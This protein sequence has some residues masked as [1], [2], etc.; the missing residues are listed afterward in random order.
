VL[1]WTL[2]AAAEDAPDEL[3]TVVAGDPLTGDGAVDRTLLT[4]T[5]LVGTADTAPAVPTGTIPDAAFALPA[6]ATM[7]AHQFSGRLDLLDENTVG[8]YTKILDTHAILGIGAVV[9]HIPEVSLELTQTGSHL[10][11][12]VQGIQITGHRFWNLIVGPG[13]AWSEQGDEGW[14]RAALPFTL[15]QRNAN[16]AHVG[17][18]MFLYDDTRVSQVRYQITQETCPYFKYD[19]WGQA[20]ASYTPYEV[21]DADAVR[22]AH[23][24]EVADR[25][26]TRPISQLAADHPEADLDLTAFGSGIT[27]EHLSTYGLLYQGVNYVSDCA[28]RQGTY[29]FCEAM[30]MS[31]FSVAKSAF[32]ATA[33][34]LLAQDRG[35][36]VVDEPIGAWV[37]E[38]ADPAAGW[39]DVTIGNVLDMAS[40]HYESADY[41]VDE[42]G[43]TANSF[44]L[45]ETYADRIA[46][47]LGFPRQA[48]PGTRWVY[49]TADTFVATTA[50]QNILGSDLFDHV[51]DRVYVPAK[52]SRGALTTSRTDNSP[53]GVPLG[54]YGLFLTRDDIAKLAMLFNNDGG[55]IAG[56]QVLDPN[57]LAAAMQRDPEDPGLPTTESA[58]SWY[59]NG[60]WAAPITP[61]QHPRYTCSF[62]VP[63]MSGYG[64][65]GV[66]MMPNGATYYYV[67]DNEE[68]AWVPAL[69]EADKLSPHCPVK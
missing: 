19:M 1:P 27:P 39:S 63:F 18:F 46:V 16:C 45:A 25:L 20:E 56:E 42:N 53:T 67:S 17:T 51:R 23:A 21:P 4:V 43:W 54:G 22:A 57:L 44:V 37:P 48:D 13:R 38:A 26:P 28:T 35:P 32:A 24:A 55:R 2:A 64:G 7:P 50:M 61:E 58:G 8:G 59:N 69:D 10:I 29:P 65:I 36:G 3:D 40:G 33:L 52:L 12:T 60:F 34:M 66:M 31:T 14:S 47:A 5:D 30:R 62:R 68:Y 41:L 49:R 15:A 11:P 6:A 9:K